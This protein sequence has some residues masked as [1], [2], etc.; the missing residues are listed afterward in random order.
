MSNELIAE[1]MAERCQ[2][3]SQSMQNEQ[4]M[5]NEIAAGFRLSPQQEHLWAVQRDDPTCC[6][7]CA[8]LLEGRLRPRALR[9]ALQAVV[10]RHEI[11]RTTFRRR[12]GM[13]A[14]LQ[15]INDRLAPAWRAADP[16]G[17]DGRG[18]EAGLEEV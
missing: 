15:V 7:Q 10:D 18:A 16:G 11:L 17:A 5:R 14:P 4:S 9:D 13:R 2:H 12:A 1:T 6:L 8:L 3:R